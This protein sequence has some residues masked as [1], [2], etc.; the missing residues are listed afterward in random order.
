MPLI[1]LLLLNAVVVASVLVT[2]WLISLKIADVSII[3]IFWGLGFVVIAWTTLVMT[4]PGARSLILTVLTT[5]WGV[6]LAGYLAWRNAGKGEDPRY[7]AMR[8]HHGDR[9]W[10]VSLFTVFFLQGIV[11][12]IVA[13]PIVVGQTTGAALSPLNY[14]GIGMWGIGFLFESLGDWQLAR[15]KAQPENRGRVMDQGL[16]RY[17]RHPNYFGNALLWWGLFIIAVSPS[18]WWLCISPLLMNF[19]LLKV[20]GVS[21]LEKGLKQR[22]QA[23][24]DYVQRTS[25]FI[26]WP[27]SNPSQASA[28]S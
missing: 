13:L 17:T 16:W 23:Y 25:P 22:S 1:Q 7:A 3:D 21:L 27:P 6:R 28:E 26:P 20:S 19:L 15:F 12:W 10:W 14:L 4:T 2:L 18:T 11:M 24:R 9:F 8:E 5:I